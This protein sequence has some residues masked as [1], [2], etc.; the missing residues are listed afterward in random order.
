MHNSVI[1]REFSLR[2]CVHF[3]KLHRGQTEMGVNE[4]VQRAG[5]ILVF[6]LSLVFCNGLFSV[7]VW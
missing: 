5:G 2:L 4:G 1:S 3:K 7:E 6:Q